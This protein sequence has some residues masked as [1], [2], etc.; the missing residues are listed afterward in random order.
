VEQTPLPPDIPIGSQTTAER[1]VLF[2]D[3]PTEALDSCES[4]RLDDPAKMTEL[5]RSGHFQAVVVRPELLAQLADD[6]RREAIIMKFSDRGQAILDTHCRIVWCNMVMQQWCGTDPRGKSFQEALGSGPIAANHRDPFQ[7]VL[8]GLPAAFRSHQETEH[9]PSYLDVNLQPLKSPSGDVAEM[10][11]LCRDVSAEV[12]QQKKLDALHKA[13]RELAALDVTQLAEMSEIERITLLK[14]N[15][16]QYIHELLHYDTIEVRLLDRQTGELKPL[17]E[18]GM[19]AEAR[20][21]VLYAKPMGNGVTGF[22]AH[23]GRSYLC[24]DTATDPHY[25][26]GASGARSS[27]TVPLTFEDAVVGTLNVESPHPNFFGQDDLQF[28][29]LFSREIAT[30]LHTLDLLA[31]Q[32]NCA[33][34]QALDFVG[35]EIALPLD[36]L[37]ASAAALLKKGESISE[38]TA[39]HLQ[40]ILDN[41]RRVKSSVKEVAE[42][43]TP[44]DPGLAAAQIL[45]GKRVLVIDQDERVRRSA[46]VLLERL[47]A[48]AETA[49]TAAEGLALLAATPYD[50]VFVEVRPIDLGGYDTYCK[51]R[52]TR[53][54]IRI[55]MTNGFGYDAAHSLVKARQDGLK[56]VLFKPF[57]QEQVVNAVLNVVPVTVPLAIPAPAGTF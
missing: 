26:L 44:P 3:A 10:L 5:L 49:G 21:R 46:H 40:R 41:A 32:Q 51:I 25:I 47:G 8:S 23:T 43:V 1:R 4:V 9:A 20:D 17:L 55:A 7:Q 50:A 54:G 39:R 16:R 6:R 11:A 45:A 27:M 35:R 42:R 34:T 30:A 33:A 36:E 53:P 56:Y 24:P 12:E 15:L 37:L 22:V 57:K 52:E 29:E 2:V 14:H 28:T 31:A 19:T 18:D 13:G 38:E 48:M